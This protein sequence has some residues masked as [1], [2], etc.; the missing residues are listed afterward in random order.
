MKGL[1]VSFALTFL[2]FACVSWAQ[3]SITFTNKDI[4]YCIDCSWFDPGFKSGVQPT[5]IG[6]GSH[7]YYGGWWDIADQSKKSCFNRD[8]SSVRFGEVSLCCLGISAQDGFGNFIPWRLTYFYKD[9]GGVVTKDSISVTIYP[10]P[11][12]TIGADISVCQND[13]PF[14]I[15]PYPNNGVGSNWLSPPSPVPNISG[16]PLSYDSVSRKHFFNP[17]KATEDTFYTLVYVTTKQYP[18]AQCQNA[19]TAMVYIRPIPNVDAGRL[20]D[21][22]EDVPVFDLTAGSGAKP[23][24]GGVGNWSGNG[25]NVQNKTFDPK[26]SG[27]SYTQPNIL[28]YCFTNDTGCT[29][30][31]TT[32][33]N[34]H[35]LPN[36]LL[37]HQ[38]DICE[39][40]GAIVLKGSAPGQ[41]SGAYYVNNFTSTNTFSSIPGPGTPVQYGPNFVRYIITNLFG[42]KKDARDSFIIYHQPKVHVLGQ[43]PYYS[44]QPFT[45]KG[46]MNYSTTLKWTRLGDGLFTFGSPQKQ[47]SISTDSIVGYTPGALETLNGWF[48]VILRS[49]DNH[50]CPASTDTFVVGIWEVSAHKLNPDNIHIYPNP[51]EKILQISLPIEAVYTLKLLDILGRPCYATNLM[52]KSLE[53]DL[54]SIQLRKG[55]YSVLVEAGEKQFVTKF[56]YR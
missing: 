18:K 36:T 51:T 27:V 17:Q 7:G 1:S 37:Q 41:G 29:A 52:G 6:L 20:S 11:M 3:V 50:L 55:V 4:G 56:V 8:S 9:T 34:V 44:G 47:D 39:N 33:I 40:T 25:V 32:F 19:D 13:N 49:T 38:Q 53:I 30:C 5:A 23:I 54:E 26:A 10:L 2:L 24:S 45:L 48:T 15:Y 42:C 22:C 46:S 31:D 43:N 16:S 12:V 28:Q 14:Q 21:V 35:K